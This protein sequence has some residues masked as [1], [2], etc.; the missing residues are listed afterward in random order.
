M[1]CFASR[2]NDRQHIASTHGERWRAMQPTDE[3]STA[4]ATNAANRWRS[5][6]KSVSMNLQFAPSFTVLTNAHTG[7][8]N[9]GLAQI[10]PAIFQRPLDLFYASWIL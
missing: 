3:P 4:S 5:M 1:L 7:T 10:L 6:N 8:A 9:A 2:S